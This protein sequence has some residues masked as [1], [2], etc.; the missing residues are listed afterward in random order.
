MCALSAQLEERAAD[1]GAPAGSSSFNL[2]LLNRMVPEHGRLGK[3]RAKQERDY[4]MGPISVSWH[5]DSSLQDDTTISVYVAHHAA[6]ADNF[7]L[8]AGAPEPPAPAPWKV[9]LRVV[10]DAEGPAFRAAGGVPGRRDDV[11][12]AVL[13]PLHDGDA[14]H[15]LAD[16]NHHHQHAVIQPEPAPPGLRVG[17]HVA[18]QGTGQG[19]GQGAAA[20]A[21]DVRYSSTHRVAVEE[22]AT[23][24]SVHRRCMRGLAGAEI[25]E[26][27]SQSLSPGSDACAALAQMAE[28]QAC[29]DLLEFE[30]LRQWYVQGAAHRDSHAA[31]WLP[32][33]RKLE[34]CW[35]ALERLACQRVRRARAAIQPGSAAPQHLAVVELLHGALSRRQRL[36]SAWAQRACD[37]IFSELDES[38]RPLT[39]LHDAQGPPL[40]GCLPG[41]LST[42][43]D[44]LAEL[45]AVQ[46]RRRVK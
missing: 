8:P 10:H 30:W 34:D 44:E 27:A 25:A 9:A 43:V 33:I 12:P 40:A 35:L 46:K 20:A 31:W 26:I 41:E 1:S 23:F 37:P 4:G 14:Y 2:T 11:T 19:A 17:L 7:A 38:Y 13:Q 36:R 28:E 24:D 18:G 6:T 42:I 16:F 22:G 5:A 15:M 3:Q 45:V 21:L 39:C 32:K 29:L